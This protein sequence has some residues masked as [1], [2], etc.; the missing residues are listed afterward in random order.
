META[1]VHCR[2]EYLLSI[3]LSKASFYLRKF[4]SP[5]LM[6]IEASSVAY[7]RFLK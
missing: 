5:W 4:G 3:N 6:F 1:L 2:F 7:C